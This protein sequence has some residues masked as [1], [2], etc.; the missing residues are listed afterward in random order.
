VT[1]R[2]EQ[3]CIEGCENLYK[4]RLLRHMHEWECNIKVDVKDTCSKVVDWTVL[5]EWSRLIG[6]SNMY[7]LCGEGIVQAVPCVH[8]DHSRYILCGNIHFYGYLFP[9]D[10]FRFFFVS[11]SGHRLD[12][13]NLFWRIHLDQDLLD[14]IIAI[15]PEWFK[16]RKSYDIKYVNLF[17]HG[18]RLA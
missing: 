11:E 12:S 9:I 15:Y 16:V 17:R 2:R 6:F 4:K 10:K 8:C 5:V 18:I 13:G 7:C 14:T 1:V 3:N